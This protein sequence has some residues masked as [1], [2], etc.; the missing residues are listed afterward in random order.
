MKIW[1]NP[2]IS[3]VNFYTGNIATLVASTG[4]NFDRHFN[5]ST[6]YTLNDIRLPQ[7]NVT[8][9]ELAQYFGYALNPRF[10]LDMFVQWNS[11][12]DL[13]TGNFRLH[14]IP[15]IGS[16]FYIVYN[17]AYDDLKH[18]NFIRPQVSGGAIKL[19]WRFTF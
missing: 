5:I 12:D 15:N 9:N 1:V 10:D 8:T 3:W 7:G 16:D 14:W 18:L 4:I 11:L 19:V 13:L 2:N 6:N 17:R